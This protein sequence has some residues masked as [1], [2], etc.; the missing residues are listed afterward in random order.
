MPGTPEY[1]RNYHRVWREKRKASGL[2]VRCGGISREGR[3]SCELC[4][5]VLSLKNNKT[6]CATWPEGASSTLADA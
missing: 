5:R 6:P 1:H 2:C 4:A 3:T